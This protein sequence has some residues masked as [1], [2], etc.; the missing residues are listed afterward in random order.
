MNRPSRIDIKYDDLSLR[1]RERQFQRDELL[2]EQNELLK[3][4]NNMLKSQFGIKQGASEF[5]KPMTLT[6]DIIATIFSTVVLGG[7]AALTC[8]YT[9]FSTFSIVL[10]VLIGITVF[11]SVLD[12]IGSDAE[13]K[14][15]DREYRKLVLEI[16]R[17]KK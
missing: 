13:R 16:E 15:R 17:E 12:I 7:V 1:E 6:E 5:S 3:E 4:R 10:A 11:C 14:R 8:Y 9:N 2:Y